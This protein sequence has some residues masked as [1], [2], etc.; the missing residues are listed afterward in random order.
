M[1]HDVSVTTLR[2]LD[3]DLLGHDTLRE[4]ADYLRTNPSAI[5]ILKIKVNV[6]SF[7]V[8]FPIENEKAPDLP[9]ETWRDRKANSLF[10]TNLGTSP[11]ENE[12]RTPARRA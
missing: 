3:A 10:P 1:S 2:N 6:K 5:H 9:K 4:H 8:I 7:E 11:L 12:L